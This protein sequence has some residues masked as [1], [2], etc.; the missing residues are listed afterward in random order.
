MEALLV[1]EIP[2][3]GKFAVR[4]PAQRIEP[5]LAKKRAFRLTI[6]AATHHFDAINAGGGYRIRAGVS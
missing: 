4:A 3:L 2:Y 6:G 1:A 5:Y